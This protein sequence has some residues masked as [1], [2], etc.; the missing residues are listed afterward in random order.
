MMEADDQKEERRGRRSKRVQAMG[1]SLRL[2]D[3]ELADVLS[4]KEA[5]QGKV[6]EVSPKSTAMYLQGPCG[7]MVPVC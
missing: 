4:S 3:Q 6:T 1:G 7:E 2:S 5:G